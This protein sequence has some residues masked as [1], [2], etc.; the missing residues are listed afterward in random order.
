MNAAVNSVLLA[1]ADAVNASLSHS[2]IEVPGVQR[3]RRGHPERIDRNAHVVMVRSETGAI[4]GTLIN[5]AIH[6]IAYDDDNLFLSADVPGG[7]EASLRQR[8]E[9]ANSGRF[10]K[11]CKKPVAVFINGAEGDISP[12]RYHREGIAEIGE[13]FS[14]TVAE[15]FDSGETLP[16]HWSYQERV[17]PLPDPGMNYRNCIKQ[18]NPGKPNTWIKFFSKDAQF[19]AVAPFF[20]KHTH[21]SLI[22]W[23]PLHLLTWPGEPTYQLGSIL[24]EQAL[25]NGAKDAMI[26]GLTN[27]HLAYFVSP[28]EY[29]DGG[30]ESC[31][32]LYG[33]SGGM[34]IIQAYRGFD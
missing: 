15:V 28:D 12:T 13:I 11:D 10:L 9:E 4:L 34:G 8:M 6:G 14:N 7:I 20:P 25:Q 16:D 23:G 22:K 19:R 26:L 1:D 31:F 3:N 27:D 32:S 29:R 5:F 17:I 24:R 21:L 18:F 33:K 30:Y 2:K